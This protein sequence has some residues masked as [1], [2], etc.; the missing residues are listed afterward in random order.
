MREITDTEIAHYHE[1][2][3]V[4]LPE[5]LDQDWIARMDTA[6]TEEMFADPAGLNHIDIGANASAMNAQGM[7]LLAS[8]PD[9]ATG[10]FWVRTFNWSRFEAVRSL[11]CDAPMPETIAHLMGSSR[12]NFYGEQVFFK[13][14]GSLHRTAFHQDAPYFHL[15]G[16]QCCTVWM[17][18]D[19]VDG[20]NGMMGYVRGSHRWDM[21]AANVFASQTP[22]PGSV[23]KQLPDIEGNEDDYDI[24][25]YP[26]RPGDAIVHHVKTVHGSTGNTASR[27]RRALA[28]RYLGDDI[29]YFEREGAAY[30]S[31]KSATLVNGDLMDSAEFPL[32]WTDSQGYITP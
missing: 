27:D 10:R 24:V 15:T 20:D 1:H 21:H 17:P 16:E 3:A 12:L 11:G 19:E 5:L 28:L 32:I 18:L 26:A 29:R 30:D 9:L 25:Y 14:A 7:T 31:Q 2:G 22:I 13:E 8:N 23:E 4:Y 6:F